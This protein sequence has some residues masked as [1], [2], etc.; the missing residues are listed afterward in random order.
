MIKSMF[1]GLLPTATIKR[2]GP[3]LLKDSRFMCFLEL[4]NSS[5]DHGPCFGESFVGKLP[6]EISL[7]RDAKCT[8]LCKSE[9]Y[10]STESATRLAY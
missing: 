9:V 8:D 4:A 6:S 1:S 3:N 5:V 2:S 10:P 7:R